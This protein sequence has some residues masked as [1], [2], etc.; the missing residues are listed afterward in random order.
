M[1]LPF[2]PTPIMGHLSPSNQDIQIRR[3]WIRHLRRLGQRDADIDLVQRNTDTDVVRRNAGIVH[4][5]HDLLTAVL[6][7][8]ITCYC[9]RR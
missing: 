5:R 7:Y 3:L 9:C 2:D 8:Y 1:V 6:C 4:V